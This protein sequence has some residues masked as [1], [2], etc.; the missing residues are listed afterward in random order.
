VSNAHQQCA[1]DRLLAQVDYELLQRHGLIVDADE[2][3][4]ESV[5]RFVSHMFA[6]V[7]EMAAATYCGRKNSSSSYANWRSFE[8]ST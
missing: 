3:V 8:Q 4:A 2:Q 5:A 1:V 6:M 7:P